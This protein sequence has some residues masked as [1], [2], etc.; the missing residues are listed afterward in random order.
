MRKGKS[1]KEE[2]RGAVAN[3]VEVASGKLP[4]APPTARRS[5]PASG[6]TTCRTARLRQE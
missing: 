6:F 2:R 4:S 5:R 1:H 3:S